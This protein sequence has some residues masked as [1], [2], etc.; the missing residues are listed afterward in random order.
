VVVDDQCVVSEGFVK[1]IY[2]GTEAARLGFPVGDPNGDYLLVF[3]TLVVMPVDR[4]G[5]IEGE[6]IYLSGPASTTKLP[7]S[8]LPE[9]YARSRQ[10][11]SG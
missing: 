7:P 6:D 9:E 2:P 3:R 5:L 1:Q 11:R 10:A 4:D 8:D